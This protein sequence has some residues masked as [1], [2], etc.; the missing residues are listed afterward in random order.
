MMQILE[1]VA[2]KNNMK[3]VVLTVLKNNQYSKFFKALKY[4]S[5]LSTIFLILNSVFHLY[6]NGEFYNYHN[7][8]PVIVVAVLIQQI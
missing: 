5:V 4:G 6:N 2:F 3:K 7:Y 1:L 8:F